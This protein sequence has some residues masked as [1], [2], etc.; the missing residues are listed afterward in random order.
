[1]FE[2]VCVSVSFAL[3]LLLLCA[4]EIAVRTLVRTK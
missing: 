1:M 2:L 3:T 4:A